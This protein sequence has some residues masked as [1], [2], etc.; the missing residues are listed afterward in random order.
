[1]NWKNP[2]KQRKTLKIKNNINKKYESDFDSNNKNYEIIN[3]RN[4][5]KKIKKLKR[6]PLDDSETI[7]YLNFK[8]CRNK[9]M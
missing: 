9:Q 4:K 2:S 6:I 1:L 7:K 8:N 5:R 3:K